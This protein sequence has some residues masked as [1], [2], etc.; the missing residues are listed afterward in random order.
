V[1]VRL[2]GPVDVTVGDVPRAVSGLRR[3]AV[4]AVLAL[5]PGKVVSTERLVQVV[6]DGTAPATAVNTLQSHISHLRQVLG[7]RTAIVARQ[8]GYVLELGPEPTD[9]RQAELLVREAGIVPT[10]AARAKQLRAA[11]SLWRGRA[12]VDVAG[13]PYLDEQAARL[14]QFWLETRQALIE[15]RLELGEHPQ[16]IPELELLVRDRPFDERLYAQLMLALYRSGRQVAALSAY[17]RLRRSLGDELGIDPSLPLRQLEAAI[18][19]Q[20]PALNLAAPATGGQ[21]DAHRRNGTARAGTPDQPGAA[22]KDGRR[23]GANGTAPGGEGQRGEGPGEGPGGDGPGGDGPGGDGPG[24]DGPGGAPGDQ[25]SHPPVAAVPRQ[26]PPAVPAFVGRVSDLARLDALLPGVLPGDTGGP[27]AVPIALISGTAGIG[28]TALAVHWGHRVSEQ[29]PD[30]QLYV[31]LRGFDP[32]G[33]ATDPGEALRGFL[34]A[35]GVAPKQVPVAVDARAALYRSLLAGRRALVV[36]D[37]ARDAEQ[38]RPLL[39]GAA[40]CLVLVTSRDQLGPLVVTE[41]AHPLSLDLLPADDAAGLLAR[42]LGAERVAA[43]PAAVEEI[44]ARC[45]RLPLAL[46]VAA[47][48]A[49]GRPEFPL[50]ALAAELREAAAALDGFDGGDATSDVRS[51]LSWSYRALSP[52]AARLFRLLGLHPGAELSLPA[53]ASVAGLPQRGARHLLAELTRAHLLTQHLPDRFSWHDLLRAYA[54]ELAG[55]EPDREREAARRRLLDHYLQASETAARLRYPDRD[56][57]DLVP[58]TEGVTVTAIGDRDAALAWYLG[59]H[60]TLLAV[61]GLAVETGFARHAWQLARNLVNYLDGQ[62]HWPELVAVQEAALTATRS[63]GDKAAQARIHRLAARGHTRLGNHAE[64]LDHHSAALVLY[65]E[66][67]D[68][69]GQAYCHQSLVRTWTDQHRYDKAL[70]HALAGYDLMVQLGH[71]VGQGR[72]LNA[73][74]WC[75]A[76]L[77]DYRQALT[78]CRRALSLQE[79]IPDQVAVPDTLDSLGYAHHQLGDH[80]EAIACYQRAL[81]LHLDLGDRYREAQLLTHLGDSQHAAGLPDAVT[82][83][84]HALVILE[85][86]KHAEASYLRVKLRRS[87]GPPGARAAILLR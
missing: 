67:D 69:L 16:L 72:L 82:S 23:T 13:V 25:D 64:S 78:Y 52:D 44:V 85:D 17:Q 50:A 55:V 20:D 18:L 5:Q 37:N 60:Q 12:L 73:I 43:E 26:L 79:N 10:G 87:S 27:G 70:T 53:A 21:Q 36:L 1:R 24:G 51:V 45:A 35:L 66:L 76:Q 46:A 57:I 80:A 42:R 31:N 8:P 58:P 2:L 22:A 4:L 54:A 9:L 49:V 47:A 15:A 29:F 59:E 3:K 14:D 86:L 77:G 68:P 84:S 48:R 30:G 62:G 74:G 40:G 34:G 71:R 39:P 28:K 19:R 83:W 56:P 11:L 81:E 6:W 75:H 63:L 41:G 61:V 33:P 7:E 32:A 65:D 38:V